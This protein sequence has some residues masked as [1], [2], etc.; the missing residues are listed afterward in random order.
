MNERSEQAQSYSVVGKFSAGLNAI[1]STLSVLAIVVMLNYLAIRHFYRF[2]I[3]ASKQWQLSPMTIRLLNSLTNDVKVI[4]CFDKSSPLYEYTYSMLREYS[5]IS[6]RIKLRL[7][8]PTSNPA[9]TEQIKSI[10]QL[11]SAVSKDLVIFDSGG[12]TKVVYSSE[13][14]DYELEPL[15]DPQKREFRRKIIAFKGEM[16]F[17]SAIL[18]VTQPRKLKAYFV[19]EHREHS[20]GSRDEITGMSKFANLLMEQ[21][22]QCELLSLLGSAEI[23]SDCNLL[24][25]AAPLDPYTSDEIDKIERYLNQ[26]G[27]MLVLFNNNTINKVI[28]LEKLLIGW[29]VVV[30]N[31]LVVDPSRQ[32]PR[33][34]GLELSLNIFGLHPIV[35]PLEGGAVHMLMPRS[36]SSIKSKDVKPDAPRVTELIFTSEQGV[37][38]TEIKDG[39]AYINP[40]RAVVGTYS[41]AAAVERGIVKGVTAGRGSTRI[42][43]VGDSFFL[44]NQMI[45]AGANRDFAMLAVNWLLDRSELLGGIGPR[46]V[47]E[48]R[49]LLNQ[50]QLS[51]LRWVLLGALPG[52]VIFIGFIVWFRRRK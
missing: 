29:G 25:I 10:Y 31:N 3:T 21:K 37:A 24:V 33:S 50:K 8:E 20:I 49:L 38:T 19:Q 32:V 34:R 40:A 26:G 18:S 47:K 35:E 45:D 42:V 11:G 2:D 28:G 23:P 12:Q 9:E 5:S 46:V 15:G 14:S 48:Y 41:V 36:V 22:I 51:S 39:V 13:L 4:I 7:I 1:I 52:S 27:R 44:C 30:G 6:P 17:T 43:V 16:V